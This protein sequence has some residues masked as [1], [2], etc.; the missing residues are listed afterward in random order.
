MTARSSDTVPRADAGD[1]DRAIA[2]LGRRGED[3]AEDDRVGPAAKYSARR[4]S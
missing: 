4:P 3:H 1:V 2:R